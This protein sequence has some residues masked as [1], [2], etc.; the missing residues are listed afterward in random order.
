MKHD[1]IYLRGRAC[2]E[3]AR[4]VDSGGV[5]EL[6]EFFCAFELFL[7]LL[8]HFGLVCHF[9]CLLLILWLFLLLDDLLKLF[10]GFWSSTCAPWGL[11]FELQTLCVC[12]QWTHRGG[13]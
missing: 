7:A 12:C 3:S 6:C 5:F 1:N 2:I 10:V 9:L 13:D 11:R 8:Y 4:G